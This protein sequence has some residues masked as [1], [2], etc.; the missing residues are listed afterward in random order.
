MGF[1][2]A[3]K[4]FVTLF[5]QI[6]ISMSVHNKTVGIITMHRVQNYGSVLQAY[7]LEKFVSRLGYEAKVID[8]IFPNKYHA[9]PIRNNKVSLMEKLKFR[10]LY[11]VKIQRRR[12]HDFITKYI[13]TTDT[14]FRTRE[15]I[16]ANPP[17][18]D[19]Y[20]TG[21]DQVWNY[22]SMNGDPT[23][24]CDFAKSKPRVS[25]AS[26]FARDVISDKF[27]DSY[28]SLLRGYEELGVRELSAV[29]II[30]DLIGKHAEVV[31]DPTLLLSPAEYDDLRSVKRIN[32]G[33]PYIL[34]YILDYAYN[35][36]PTIISVIDKAR[37]ELG[38]DVIYLHANSINN[39]HL[40]K[41]ITDAG[42]KE[43]LQLISQASFV[44]TSSF[45]GV[46]FSLNFGIPFYAITPTVKQDDRIYSLLYKV[47]A[48]SRA[49]PVGVSIKEQEFSY[50]MDY[51]MIK[52]NLDNYRTH[53]QEF[54]AMALQKSSEIDV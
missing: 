31:C 50:E 54:L 21:S 36:Y 9:R 48:T 3:F 10:L 40:G 29:D 39:Y 16:S 51:I 30:R 53:S 34:A 14:V 41:S 12:F 22:E 2:E 47:G 38:I 17:I 35:P 32:N 46:A 28:A 27:K 24:F 7:A 42:P 33:K 5:L 13:N 52:Q 1:S 11:R 20:I 25:F 15:A 8:Y 49:I 19:I 37:K 45:H 43:F 6:V 4:A 18:F 44:V 23:F 26:S